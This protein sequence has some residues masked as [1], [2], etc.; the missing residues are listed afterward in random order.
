M[1]SDL[2]RK[3]VGNFLKIRREKAGLTQHDVAHHLSYTSP[4]FVSNWERGISM[5]PLDALPRLAE[6]YRV[7]GKEMIDTVYRY[8]D[9]VLK[10]QKKQ[11]AEMFRKG[12]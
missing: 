6:L 9:Q 12:R 3:I 10:L 5:P 11:L 1:E 8:Q 4:Q 7:A 2:R